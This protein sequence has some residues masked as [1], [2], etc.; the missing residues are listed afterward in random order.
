MSKNLKIFFGASLITLAIVGYKLYTMPPYED[1]KIEP[2]TY[3]NSYGEQELIK[4][5]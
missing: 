5:K 3:I 4:K 1:K 2:T